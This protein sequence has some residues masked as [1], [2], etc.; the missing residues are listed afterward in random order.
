[1]KLE[2][3]FVHLMFIKSVKLFVGFFLAICASCVC[4]CDKRQQFIV[5]NFLFYTVLC[6]SFVERALRMDLSAPKNAQMLMRMSKVG[7]L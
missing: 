1:V 6:R 2:I 7:L 4:L 3:S 5:D